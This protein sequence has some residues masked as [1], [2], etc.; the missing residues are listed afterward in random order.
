MNP[1]MNPSPTQKYIREHTPSL[2]DI[3][4]T[5]RQF[6]A[7]TGMGFGALSLASLFG[8]NPY[9][10]DAVTGAL[11]KGGPQAEGAALQNEGRSFTFSRKVGRRT[12]IRG[13][14]AGARAA[15]T[16]RF[17][18][19]RP[20]LRRRSSSQDGKSGIEVSEGFPK[21]GEMVDDM[22]IIRSLGRA[23]R[24]TMGAGS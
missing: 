22:T 5:R 18:A 3:I 14:E 8:M 13:P 16:R 17:P 20:R 12:S 23:F 24:R 7:R 2:D 4:F 15:T 19:T 6:L 21:L 11:A 1:D 9:E 10:A